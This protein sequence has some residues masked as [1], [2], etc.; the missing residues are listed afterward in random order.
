MIKSHI[1]FFGIID[2]GVGRLAQFQYTPQPYA[3]FRMGEERL[4]E[5]ISDFDC[6]GFDTTQERVALA[7]LGRAG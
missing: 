2:W 1:M 4:R 7:A 5:H 3:I 6:M